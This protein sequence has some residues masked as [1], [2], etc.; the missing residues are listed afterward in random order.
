MSKIEDYDRVRDWIIKGT[1]LPWEF[2]RV[3]VLAAIE[4]ATLWQRSL[5]EPE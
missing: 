2:L 5:A 4:D 3:T 1:P